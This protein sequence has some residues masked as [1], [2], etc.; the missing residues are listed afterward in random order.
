[1]NVEK[2]E[3]V[4]ALQQAVV[5]TK[6]KYDAA[7][8]DWDCK[9]AVFARE[10]MWDLAPLLGWPAEDDH[11]T[12][13]V[14][15]RGCDGA[16]YLR[17]FSTTV[18]GAYGGDYWLPLAWWA[19]DAAAWTAHVKVL[20]ESPDRAKKALREVKTGPTPSSLL[21]EAV[22]ELVERATRRFN[23]RVAAGENPGEMMVA[24]LLRVLA[25]N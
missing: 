24:A 9:V 7:K 6:S 13:V 8:H 2:H 15:E 5:T 19:M 21:D 1:M 18:S 12:E 23:E 20:T 3:G 11:L 4:L 14:L 17:I 22:D 16:D 10:R 25:R